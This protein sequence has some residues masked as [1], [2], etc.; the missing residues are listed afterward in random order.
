MKISHQ[1]IALAPLSQGKNPR[2]PLNRRFGGSRSQYEHCVEKKNFFI[3]VRNLRFHE[4]S[5][6]DWTFIYRFKICYCACS[7]REANH[8]PPSSANVKNEWSYTSTPTYV[9]MAWCLVKYR[10]RLHGVVLS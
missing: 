5:F 3:T 10:I 8:S 7:G 2:Y 4:V 9:F 6:H 1:L